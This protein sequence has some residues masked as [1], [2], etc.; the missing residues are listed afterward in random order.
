M[1]EQAVIQKAELRSFA[2]VLAIGD[3]HGNCALLKKLLCTA[4][5]DR[6]DALVLVG[7]LTE[8]GTDSLGTIRLAMELMRC[9]NVW[10]ATG[11]CETELLARLEPEN[12]DDLH[13]YMEMRR[14]DGQRRS[15]LWEMSAE[16]G[17][18]VLY[19]QDIFAFQRELQKRFAPE[20]DFLHGLPAIAESEDCIFVHAGLESPNLSALTQKSCVRQTAFL[21]QPG[22]RFSKTVIVGHWPAILYGKDHISANPRYS[23]GRNVFAIDGGCMV[24]G[25]GQLNCLIRDNATGCWSFTA[26]DDLPKAVALSAQ[27][28][29]KGFCFLWGDNAVEPLN[30]NGS[31]TR[32]RHLR[33]GHEAEIPTQLL[34]HTNGGTFVSNFTAAALQLFPGDV[35]SVIFRTEKGWYVKKDGVSGWYSGELKFC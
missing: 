4:G 21:S 3:M 6:R 1:R 13:H 34:Y 14:A 20:L 19:E 30:E 10:C 35:V 15:L 25:D 26:C 32:C 8:K 29:Q 23:A 27:S 33:T 9:G 18:D 12:A 5:F 11:N 31:F 24:H 22:R 2:R 16:A 17:L 28:A 7:D